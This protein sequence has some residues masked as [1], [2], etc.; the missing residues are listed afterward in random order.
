[1]TRQDRPTLAVLPPQTPLLR[2]L[3]QPSIPAVADQ[4][5]TAQHGAISGGGGGGGVG[6]GA[7]GGGGANNTTPNAATVTALVRAGVRHIR[8]AQAIAA[9]VAPETVDRLIRAGFRGGALVQAVRTPGTLAAFERPATPATPAPAQ[10]RPEAAQAR[11]DD[12]Q[13]RQHEQA[14]RTASPD[15]RAAALAQAVRTMSPAIARRV[16]AHLDGVPIEHAPAERVTRAALS[17]FARGPVAAALAAMDTSRPALVLADDADHTSPHPG[18]QTTPH[19]TPQAAHRVDA[20][21]A[22]PVGA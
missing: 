22:A 8:T 6:G 20:Q 4:P 15:H 12:A 18:P 1:M 5:T 9:T 21:P 13:A 17:P 19:T 14:I 11:Q 16:L 2:L 10:A 7:R 3:H